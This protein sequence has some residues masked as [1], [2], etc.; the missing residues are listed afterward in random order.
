MTVHRAKACLTGKN[1]NL[2]NHV[3][4]EVGWVRR[5]SKASRGSK[6]L[7]VLGSALPTIRVEDC[8]HHETGCLGAKDGGIGRKRV[9]G[10]HSLTLFPFIQLRAELENQL[11]AP[12]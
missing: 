6:H 11:H 10:L 8:I 12:L 7:T 5:G 9:W 2:S 4:L 1:L 3:S